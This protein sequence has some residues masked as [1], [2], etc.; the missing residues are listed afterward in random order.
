M[1]GTWNVEPWV[2]EEV[3][4]MSLIAAG[5][6]DAFRGSLPRRR[7][8]F[9]E[10]LARAYDSEWRVSLEGASMIAT[11][12]F[13]LGWEVGD[14][15]AALAELR[16]LEEHSSFADLDRTA[17]EQHT[18]HSASA[19]LVLGRIEEA[20][21]AMATLLDP[22]GW[23]G[24]ARRSALQSIGLALEAIGGSGQ[25]HL[26]LLDLVHRLLEGVRGNGRLTR[27]L[28][29]HLSWEELADVVRSAR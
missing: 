27:R 17:R 10:T 20:K 6:L 13:F 18:W 8:I 21:D 22:A 15:E 2:W 5:S 19:L 26:Q 24:P 29:G 12:G 14:N 1:P 9:A 16:R 7:V 28:S 11:N 4:K 23:K 3:E 25:A